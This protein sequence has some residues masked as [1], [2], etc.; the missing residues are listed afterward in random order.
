[1]SPRKTGITISTSV[2]DSADS[3]IQRIRRALEL[4]VGQDVLLADATD[5]DPENVESAG[6]QE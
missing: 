2:V 6:N 5:N 3:N 1:M 4:I